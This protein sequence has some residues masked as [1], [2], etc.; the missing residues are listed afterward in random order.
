MGLIDNLRITFHNLYNEIFV[1]N[2]EK[3]HRI[4]DGI[5]KD[6]QGNDLRYWNQGH[7]RSHLVEADQDEKIKMIYGVPKLLIMVEYMFIWP[8]LAHLTNSPDT[9]MLWGFETL[10]G[11]WYA[12]YNWFGSK[13]A[14]CRTYLA[15]D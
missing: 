14:N 2:R 9:P 3:V 5:Y 13:H 12:K 1:H 6:R 4:K 8:L 7:S 15:L 11:G 10:K